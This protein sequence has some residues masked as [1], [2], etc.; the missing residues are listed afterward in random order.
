MATAFDFC[1]F[2]ASSGHSFTCVLFVFECGDVCYLSIGRNNDTMML[3]FPVMVSVYP[4]REDNYGWGYVD[5]LCLKNDHPV[6]VALVRQDGE[7]ATEC[8]NHCRI[9][10]LFSL[11]IL[12]KLWQAVDEKRRSNHVSLEMEYS[13]PGQIFQRALL[14]LRV[15]K[16]CDVDQIPPESSDECQG[17]ELAVSLF[18]REYVPLKSALVPSD[19]DFVIHSIF[20]GT[21]LSCW[22]I[23]SFSQSVTGFL[24][25]PVDNHRNV[26]TL[27]LGIAV[28]YQRPLKAVLMLVDR[29][30][31][32][33][34]YSVK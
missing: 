15:K 28:L 7:W 19:S 4:P 24:P 12:E 11:I 27:L 1:S 10:F 21:G 20:E 13:C 5:L 23:D 8:S 17:V 3:S 9:A 18:V 26:S 34:G 16:S 31:V 29:E 2:T 32:V 33:R 25:D 14:H 22:R 30:F 6:V